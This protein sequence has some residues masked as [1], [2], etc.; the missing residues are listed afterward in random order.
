MKGQK[1]LIAFGKTI[2]ALTQVFGVLLLL[3]MG[4]AQAANQQYGLVVNFS[5]V[6]FLVNDPKITVNMSVGA[7][8]GGVSV[9]ANGVP[10][11][12]VYDGSAT[13]MFNVTTTRVNPADITSA[14]LPVSVVATA[15]NWT[16]G[17]TGLAT[18][19]DLYEGYK[20]AVSNTFDN[21]DQGVWD[22]AY[23]VLKTYAHS[24]G[25]PWK[26]GFS[27][28]A[29]DVNGV[30]VTGSCGS[31]Y[32]PSSPAS[33]PGAW[34]MSWSEIQTFQGLGWSVYNE[35]WDHLCDLS[36][37]N[38]VTEDGNDQN[39]ATI[40][41]TTYPGLATELPNYH[42]SHQIY[43]YEDSQTVVA[44]GSPVWPPS[45]ILSGEGNYG[46][47]GPDQ[48]GGVNY[49]G[50][51][52]FT[53]HPEPGADRRPQRR[54]LPRHRHPAPNPGG[55]GPHGRPDPGLLAHRGVPP[56]AFGLDYPDRL[57]DQCE[58]PSNPLELSPGH[59][60]DRR[61]Q[62]HVVRPRGGSDGLPLYPQRGHIPN[63]HAGHSHQYLHAGRAH[64]H[65]HLDG[66]PD[67]HRHRHSLLG[68]RL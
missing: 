27:V 2:S 48:D 38:A 53:L 23:P 39:G 25:T 65:L 42:V 49:V 61:E 11:S 54:R 59:L 20:F 64:G 19:S 21:G 32:T 52:L 66:H 37:A 30:N 36:C 13:V 26:A 57:R 31:S 18:K 40:G 1:H 7:C 58:H 6:T 35:T 68:E 44:C 28:I 3:T 29:A 14:W 15:Y 5:P 24:D 47:G 63:F 33:G 43:P 8:T 46:A 41:T 51:D 34:N 55:F 17:G 10:V 56:G 62:F 60:W 67:R 45:Y 12:A 16:S 9:T 50:A 4:T 22:Y